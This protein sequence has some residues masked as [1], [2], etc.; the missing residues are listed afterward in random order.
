MRAAYYVTVCQNRYLITS[1]WAAAKLYCAPEEIV[2][3]QQHLNDESCVKYGGVELVAYDEV[4]GNLTDDFT[5]NLTVVGFEDILLDAAIVFN[6]SILVEEELMNIA[7]RTV[8]CDSFT[9]K[10]IDANPQ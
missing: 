2:V 5:K 10:M 4:K 7:I 6:Q 9:S 3:G 1:Q 8:V